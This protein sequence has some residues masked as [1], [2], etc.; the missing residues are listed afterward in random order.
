MS[1]VGQIIGGVVGAVVG[2]YV[3]GPYGAVVGASMGM[4]LGAYIDPIR[5]DIPQPGQ[6]Q[7]S[8]LNI[9]T[10]TEGST[11]FDVLGTTKISAANFIW[12]GNSR[13]VAVEETQTTEGGKG[14]G[15]TSTTY[16]T[17]YEY[18][19]SWA[20]AICSGPISAVHTIYSNDT[21]VYNE[22]LYA[23]DYPA[24]YAD[25]TL[26]NGMGA[27][28][29]YFGTETQ[30][31]DPTM[32][33]A[34]G[35]TITPP[36]RGTAY[37][38]FNDVLI[39]D[40]NRAPS[41]RFVVSKTPATALTTPGTE[42]IDDIRYVG[43][44]DYNPAY[45]VYYILTFHLDFKEEWINTQ[46]FIS[47]AEKLFVEGHGLSIL[48][49]SNAG[50]INY[51]ETILSHFQGMLKYGNDG[52]FHLKLFRKD[53][54]VYDLE[55]LDED[56]FTER[57]VVDRGSHMEL[58]NEL[59]TQYSLM[60]FT[61]ECVKSAPALTMTDYDAEVSCE[62]EA[63][64][65]I[66]EGCPPYTLQ[67]KTYGDWGDIKTVNTPFKWLY[68]PD[69]C[70]TSQV[71]IKDVRGT[72]SNALTLDKQCGGNTGSMVVSERS[73]T[74]GDSVSIT[75]S[76]TTECC[77]VTV[78]HTGLSGDDI[79]QTSS[80]TWIYTSPEWSTC[81][82][83]LVTF[84]LKSCGVGLQTEFLTVNP[85]NIVFIANTSDCY[86]GGEPSEI[87]ISP[88]HTI[89]SL[90]VAN[91]GCSV[92][93]GNPTILTTPAGYDTTVSI[94]VTMVDT[95]HQWADGSN[96]TGTAVMSVDDCDCVRD[97]SMAWDE[98][99]SD[100]YIEKS[101]SAIIAVT[102]NNFPFTWEVEG[103]GFSL[104]DTETTG[105]SNTLYASAGATGVA[106]IT[107]VGCDDTVVYGTVTECECVDVGEPM[108]PYIGNTHTSWCF[109]SGSVWCVDDV[110]GRYFSHPIVFVNM[111]YYA[112]LESATATRASSGLGGGDSSDCGGYS[113]QSALV[114]ADASK[115]NAICR[116][117]CTTVS[118]PT[119]CVGA[120]AYRFYY[121]FHYP[122]PTEEIDDIATPQECG[123]TC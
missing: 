1:T 9:N 53:E 7:I 18:Y 122:A 32:A 56:D 120:G 28:R 89:T 35:T 114:G 42:E 94:L 37:A 3:G 20:L 117:R 63:T 26:G 50:A 116:I 38:L 13:S 23:A 4:G 64:Y 16:V 108:G 31:Q 87:S 103:T 40:Y 41:M 104:E 112:D 62:G 58:I 83:G 25:I 43:V 121:F 61:S 49:D 101:G 24:G 67:F 96:V 106:S 46:S 22:V 111:G 10:S 19:L 51:L 14:G 91:A 97:E 90:A 6:P 17:G 76:G 52:K 48:F 105:L 65:A 15:S 78:E 86:Y 72:V 102:G 12:Y 36:Y 88:S 77:D 11:L 39:G 107:V 75:V 5:P 123:R 2:Y 115:W 118:S 71:R 113:V 57:P 100:L 98:Y 34:L 82:G 95:S 30:T 80:T 27:C 45:A 70:Y 119:A 44:Y 29:I 33:A 74:C 73:I 66:A 55:V 92:T 85:Q 8:E 68:K 21:S 93:Q 54:E 99:T 69:S 109:A 84:T 47:A 59:R 60:N 79:E 110:Q 81:R